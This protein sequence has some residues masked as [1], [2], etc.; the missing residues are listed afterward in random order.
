MMEDFWLAY[1]GYDWLPLNP[2]MP[3]MRS[4]LRRDQ[5]ECQHKKAAH[6]VPQ[7]HVFINF[8]TQILTS[9]NLVSNILNSCFDNS[10]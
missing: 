2:S 10:K 7:T 9:H 6:S 5:R 3:H 8:I 1:G 4:H